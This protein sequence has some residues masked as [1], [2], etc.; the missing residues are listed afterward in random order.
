MPARKPADKRQNRVTK[1]PDTTVVVG[2]IHGSGVPDAPREI[3]KELQ[4]SWRDYWISPLAAATDQGSKLAAATR[5]WQMYDMRDKHY[6]AYRVAPLVEGSQGQMVMNPLGRQL[7]QLETQINALED[8]L[9]LNPKAQ[10][11]LG[12]QWAAGQ[13]QLADLADRVFAKS[14]EPDDDEIDPRTLV[15]VQ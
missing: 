5:L 6:E 4:A 9:G 3:T 13:S 2:R 12:I 10:L 1:S 11:A 14:S 15:A 8:R 7:N